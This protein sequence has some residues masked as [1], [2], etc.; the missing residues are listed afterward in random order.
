METVTHAA[1]RPD[2]HMKHGAAGLTPRSIDVRASAAGLTSRYD[3]LLHGKIA[4]SRRY[5]GLQRR[6][7]GLRRG[8]VSLRSANNALS[9]RGYASQRL[10]VTKYTQKIRS[11]LRD[12]QSYASA[13][14]LGDGKIGR[15]DGRPTAVV[16]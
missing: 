6:G 13:M 11:C 5:R 2:N 10:L 14:T 16:R 8:Y 7:T 3:D 9:R 15:P 4:R 12:R 1:E